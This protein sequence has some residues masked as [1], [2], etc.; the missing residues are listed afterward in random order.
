MYDVEGVPRRKQCRVLCIC[1]GVDTTAVVTG[2]GLL[3]SPLVL[4][5]ETA[6]IPS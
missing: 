5:L 4:S 1:A 2:Y 3:C 6:E